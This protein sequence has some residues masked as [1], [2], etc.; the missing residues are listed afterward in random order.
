MLQRGDD[1]IA[2]IPQLGEPAPRKLVRARRQRV[3]DLAIGGTDGQHCLT[4]GA[5]AKRRDNANQLV[6]PRAIGGGELDLGQRGFEP[7][8]A[9]ADSTQKIFA[10]WRSAPPLAGATGN[11][12]NHLERGERDAYRCA[13]KTEAFGDFVLGDELARLDLAADQRSPQP[14]N[15]LGDLRVGAR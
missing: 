7:Q 9:G 3:A 5:L 8:P 2:M 14:P 4:V 10:D 12:T 13:A 1:A 6:E 15:G 11:E